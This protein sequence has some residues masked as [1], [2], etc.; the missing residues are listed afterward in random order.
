MKSKFNLEPLKHLKQLINT[1]N[2]NN[3]EV[4]ACVMNEVYPNLDS[5]IS[6]G[7]NLVDMQNDLLQLKLN[8]LKRQVE[9]NKL[10][11]ENNDSLSKFR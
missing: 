8:G 5:Y 11:K 2:I 6:F 9:L 7:Q 3:D 4:L 10:I 1:K